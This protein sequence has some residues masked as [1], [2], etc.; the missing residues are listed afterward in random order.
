[1]YYV[2]TPAI[3]SIIDVMKT[4]VWGESRF[5]A[6][7]LDQYVYLFA[8]TVLI[9]ALHMVEHVAQVIQKFVLH[10]VP[11]H[12]LIGALDLEQV[13]FAFNVLYLVTLAVVMVGWF[14]FG[15]QLC[16]RHKALAAL[17]IGTVP[18]RATT[19]SSTPSNWPSS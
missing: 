12:G 17:L 7:F 18:S 14:H 15:S 8:L 13:H 10:I 3:S 1:M 11:A 4:T 19:W 5:P 2:E 6:R 9:Q 16:S